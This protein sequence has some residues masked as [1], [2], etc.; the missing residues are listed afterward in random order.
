MPTEFTDQGY[1]G[2]RHNPSIRYNIPSLTHLF[3]IRKPRNKDNTIQ[4]EAEDFDE[5]ASLREERDKL[6]RDLTVMQKR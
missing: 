4:P 1:I 2:K 3:S 5:L 6:Y